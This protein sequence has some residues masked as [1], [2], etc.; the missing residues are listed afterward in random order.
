[1][2]K[3]FLKRQKWDKLDVPTLHK[4]IE[5]TNSRASTLTLCI[6]LTNQKGDFS[7]TRI[8]AKVN[9]LKNF[10]KYLETIADTLTDKKE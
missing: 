2:D 10:A 8:T 3:K 6:S 1:M 5:I 9:E 7:P 4:V